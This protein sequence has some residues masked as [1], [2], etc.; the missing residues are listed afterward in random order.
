MIN[1]YHIK[2]NLLYI[3]GIITL[4][5]FINWNTRKVVKTKGSVHIIDALQEHPE[6][7]VLIK[8]YTL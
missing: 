1:P 2:W 5:T 6:V 8:S 3:P 4:L 7:Q